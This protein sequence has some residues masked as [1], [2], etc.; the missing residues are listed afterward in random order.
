MDLAVGTKG[1]AVEDRIL[2]AA[3]CDLFT[4][5]S[6]TPEGRQALRD[7]G[8]KPLPEGR[9]ALS[10]LGLPSKDVPRD[11]CGVPLEG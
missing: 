8:F 1:L 3:A 11:A 9:Q 4:A 7:L 2:C 5:L 10:D 6:A